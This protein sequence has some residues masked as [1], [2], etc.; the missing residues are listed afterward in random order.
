M[1]LQNE[2]LVLYKG[3]YTYYSLVVSEIL[4]KEEYI[5]AGPAQ[6][7]RLLYIVFLIRR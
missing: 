2:T 1:A 7:A 4:I 5:A 3:L 6:V